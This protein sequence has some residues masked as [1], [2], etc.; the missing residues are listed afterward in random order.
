[1]C[2]DWGQPLSNEI[3]NLALLHLQ[4]DADRSAR[5][6]EGHRP[7]E[8]AEFLIHA[9][10][11]YS[12]AVLAR[13]A[14]QVASACLE[15]FP[16]ETRPQVLAELPI[17]I[18]AAV[19]RR[20]PQ[21]GRDSVLR[22]LPAPIVTAINRAIRYPPESAGAL[23]DPRE[24]TLYDDLKVEEAIS[25]L[26]EGG[27]PISTAI[28]VLSRLQRVVGAV[29]PAK[30]L[31]ALPEQTLGALGLDTVRTPSAA[32]PVSAL[33]ADDRFGAGP[34]AVVDHSGIFVGVL[35]KDTLQDREKRTSTRPTARLVAD[36]AE[37]YWVGLGELWVGLSNTPG[38][39]VETG[40]TALG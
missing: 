17:P 26:R 28:F 38:L 30:L 11:K 20:L 22:E 23:A 10:A 40:E 9:P 36:I 32:V 21:A 6:L 19:L 31:C 12:A 8:V 7:A 39:T 24:R 33:A 15:H 25:V 4:H 3:R 2:V 29:T 1:M 16:S 37:L 14:P 35:S 5:I 13:L 27:G 34:L 18:A